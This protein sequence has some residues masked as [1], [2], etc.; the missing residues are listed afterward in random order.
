MTLRDM[1]IIELD[2]VKEFIK[3]CKKNELKYYMLGGTLLG[4]IRHKGFIPWDDDIDVGMP[5]PDYERFLEII[6]NEMPASYGIKTFNNSDNFIKYHTRLE[7]RNY[8]FESSSYGNNQKMFSW[9]DVFPLDGMPNNK[10]ML[11]L[12]KFHLLYLRAMTQL[13]QFN[14][15]IDF[16]NKNRPFIEKAIIWAGKYLGLGRNK[17]PKK[18]MLALDKALKK[19]SYDD[20]KYLVNFMGAYKFREM[21]EKSKYLDGKMYDFEDIQLCGPVDYDFVLTQLYGDYMIPP[22]EQEKNRH[23]T[24]IVESK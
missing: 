23:N 11:E 19:Y 24:V 20:S 3:I 16:S 6:V 14:E 12:H 5:R 22:K 4:A 8:T 21:F 7:N 13:S 17:D 15:T 2:I 18:T 1:Q 9:I 10:I